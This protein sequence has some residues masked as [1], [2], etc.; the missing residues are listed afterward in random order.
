M[1]SLSIKIRGRRIYDQ[2]ILLDGPIQKEMAAINDDDRHPLREAAQQAF[3]RMKEEIRAGGLAFA[4]AA[5]EGP[6]E[7]VL[8]RAAYLRANFDDVVLL[9]T[10][11]SSLGGRA[12]DGLYDELDYSDSRKPKLHFI[13]NLNPH[14]MTALLDRLTI[15]KTHY[16]VISKSGRTA[17]TLAQAGV[18][19]SKVKSD[20]DVTDPGRHFTV[21]TK[22]GDQLLRRF[23][24]HHGLEIF[25]HP[26]DL[27]GRYSVFSLVGLLPAAIAGVDIEKVLEGA[28][29]VLGQMEGC[30]DV[31]QF[32]AAVGAVVLN[33]LETR[34]DHRIAALISYDNRLFWFGKWFRQLWAES[35]GK[36]GGGTT[37]VGGLGPADQ[38]SQL[39]LYLDGPKDK[40]FTVISEDTRGMGPEIPAWPTENADTAAIAGKTIGDVV[41]AERLALVQTLERNG[42]PV[43]HLAID[44]IGEESLGALLMHLM[45][46]TVFLAKL[47]GID[48]FNQPA[49]ESCKT[50]IEANLDEM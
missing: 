38:H 44:E 33:V 39:Q 5:I 29:A 43:R 20:R 10:G 25:D 13:D 4:A 8:E 34:F 40:F 14:S 28:R 31:L 1:L 7:R 41:Y 47:R 16:L 2:Q 12:L 37:P 36:D 48:P 9:G 22:P 6:D 50:Q 49:V 45:L 11:G 24:T 19:M 32:P 35:L 21:I 26:P 3:N 27:G 42:L 17:E 18:V 46:E 23:A 30:K 15:S